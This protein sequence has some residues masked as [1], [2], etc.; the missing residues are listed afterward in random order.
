[1]AE[2]IKVWGEGRKGLWSFGNSVDIPDDYVEIEPGDAYV[3]RQVKLRSA[4][5]YCRMKKSRRRKFSELVGILAPP[6]IVEEVLADAKQTKDLRKA[7]NA[8]AAVH[9]SRKEAELNQQRIE[10]LKQMLPGIPED[11]AENVVK[12][13]FEVGSGRVGRTSSLTDEEKLRIATLAHIRHCHTDY[14]AMLDDGIDREEARECVAGKIQ[15][16]YDK[17][18]YPKLKPDH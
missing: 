6:E 8:V 18:A 12:R 16:V 13:A 15:R 7:R 4:A 17:W 1:M 3:T 2:E 9:R 5:V 10:T 11:D 14:E